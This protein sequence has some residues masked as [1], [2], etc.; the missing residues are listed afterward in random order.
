MSMSKLTPEQLRRIEENKQR[1]LAKLAQKGSCQNEQPSGKKTSTDF[2]VGKSD[3]TQSNTFSGVNRPQDAGLNMVSHNLYGK[4]QNTENTSTSKLGLD[5]AVQDRIE[6]NRQKALARRAEKLNQSPIKSDNSSYGS[7]P[8]QRSDGNKFSAH[9]QN[10]TGFQNLPLALQTSNA[11]GSN[12]EQRLQNNLAQK[13]CMNNGQTGQQTSAPSSGNLQQ[14]GTNIFSSFS[15][16]PV[17]GDC[18]LVSRDRFE[19]KAGYSAPLIELFKT[20]NTKL[21]G[22]YGC[23]NILNVENGTIEQL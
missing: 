11:S 20:M 9:G 10:A 21:Y 13:G 23:N 16:K 1:A 19:V 2:S 12:P 14:K 17:K 18:V 3:G 7:V 5:S 22:R 15:G 6:Q 4:A 8:G